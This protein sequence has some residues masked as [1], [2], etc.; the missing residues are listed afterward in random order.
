MCRNKNMSSKNGYLTRIFEEASSAT[1]S[2]SV[3]PINPSPINNIGNKYNASANQTIVKP[4]PMR[5]DN[6]YN[7]SHPIR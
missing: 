6:G 2:K 5:I 4:I 3:S 7:V 1:R